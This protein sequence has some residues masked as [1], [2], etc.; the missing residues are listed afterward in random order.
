MLKNLLRYIK[1]IKYTILVVVAVIFSNM[2]NTVNNSDDG[3]IVSPV[4]ADVPL[5]GSV[6]VEGSGCGGEGGGGSCG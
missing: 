4:F 1:I 2:I 3:N 5:E 6:A